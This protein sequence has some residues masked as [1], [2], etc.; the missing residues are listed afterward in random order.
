MPIPYVEGASLHLEIIHDYQ[1]KLFPRVTAASITK[2]LGV[3]LSPVMLVTITLDS[4]SDLHAV[5]KLYD[6]RFGKN[7]RCTGKA[8]FPYTV[9]NQL[10]FEEFVR[11][12]AIGPFLTE[13]NHD[14]KTAALPKFSWQYLDGNVGQ[15]KRYEAALWQECEDMFNSEVKA[16]EHLKHFQGTGIPH[17]LASIRLVNSSSIIPSDLI[18]K[19]TA[20][21]WDVKG[22]LLQYIPGSTLIK[23]DS[24][25]I[26]VHEWETILEYAR[27]LVYEINKAGV[28]IKNCSPRNVIVDEQSLRPFAIDF[29]QSW[30]RDELEMEIP[31]HSSQES[32]TETE[33]EFEVDE[34]IELEE[35]DSLDLEAEYWAM[36]RDLDNPGAI[37][38]VMTTILQKRGIK[39]QINH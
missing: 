15:S 23:F 11:E 18:D 8:W 39:V 3:S 28:V 30:L 16:Y 12:N 24:L 5:L 20:K 26:K 27:D 31:V 4:G 6:S 14:K 2:I 21:Y 29:A 25:S 38:A 32:G 7:L 37:G 13:L 36:V 1:D 22:V 19:P 17:L 34:D 9:D 10:S 35:G 33:E